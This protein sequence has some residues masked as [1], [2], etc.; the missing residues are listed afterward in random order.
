MRGDSVTC[1]YSSG[2][3]ARKVS[4]NLAKTIKNDSTG[5]HGL[6]ESDGDGLPKL[7]DKQE[8]FVREYMVDWNATQAA[9]RAGYSEKTASEMAYQL[10]HKTSVQKAI[11][12]RAKERDYGVV[13]MRYVHCTRNAVA[14]V[15]ATNDNKLTRKTNRD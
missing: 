3:V 2:V 4:E 10:L 15:L 9:I 7:T 6:F 11:A 13:L 1:N 5:N 12:T 14:E 8:I